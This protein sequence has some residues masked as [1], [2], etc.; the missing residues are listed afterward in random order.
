MNKHRNLIVVIL[1][2]A[3]K[4]ISKETV[5]V[6]K[7]DIER[8]NLRNKQDAERFLKSEWCAKLADSIGI[9]QNKIIHKVDKIK[10]EQNGGV[11]R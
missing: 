5:D 1:G 10:E 3:V 11:T 6:P 4:D 7:T 9:D 2:Q 8:D